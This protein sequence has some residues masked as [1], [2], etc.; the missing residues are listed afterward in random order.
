MKKGTKTIRKVKTNNQEYYVYDLD[1]DI[2]GKRRRLY[3]KTEEELNERIRQAQDI[4][5][6]QRSKLP[7]G[8]K[9]KDFVLYYFRMASGN[10]SGTNMKRLVNLFENAVFDSSIDRNMNELTIDEIQ[11]FYK[12]LT[13]KYATD[14]IKD[15]DII[16]GNIFEITNKAGRTDLDYSAVSIPE[17]SSNFFVPDYIAS[18]EEL[19]KMLDFCLADNCRKYKANELFI[20]FMLLTGLAYNDVTKIPCDEV[21]LS[22]PELK[23]NGRTFA[24]DERTAEWLKKMDGEEKLHISSHGGGEMLFLDST[25]FKKTLDAILKSC[26]LPKTITRKSLHKSCIIRKIEEGVSPA[27]LYKNYGYKSADEITSMYDEY[28]VNK[29]LFY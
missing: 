23:T 24:L 1:K 10:I 17:A 20:T 9:L 13:N 27:K 22:I 21:D 12:T 25:G 19:D 15:I 11:D 26:G 4:M 6:Q 18:A 2:F 5:E 8:C 29:K 3:G 16:M 28:C 14:N 7:D